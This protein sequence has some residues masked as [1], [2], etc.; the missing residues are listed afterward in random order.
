MVQYC[1][2][3]SRQNS[4]S[5]I[6]TLELII[7]IVFSSEIKSFSGQIHKTTVWH[8]A[9]FFSRDKNDEAVYLLLVRIIRRLLETY[10]MAFHF[11]CKKNH[12]F[13]NLRSVVIVAINSGLSLQHFKV[14][15]KTQKI[16]I[17]RRIKWVS[18][19]LLSVEMPNYSNN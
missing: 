8:I 12:T 16:S 1:R 4:T 6:A 9:A 17:H 19:V 15:K 11:D 14:V 18:K 10:M 5:N 3:V 2:K 7:R 13:F